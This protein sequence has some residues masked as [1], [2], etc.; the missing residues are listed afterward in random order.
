MTESAK[1]VQQWLNFTGLQPVSCVWCLW[2]NKGTQTAAWVPTKSVHISVCPFVFSHKEWKFVLWGHQVL[3]VVLGM[4]GQKPMCCLYLLII[5]IKMKYKN[6]LLFFFCIVMML[7]NL[8][9]LLRSYYSRF[10]QNNSDIFKILTSPVAIIRCCPWMVWSAEAAILVK[11]HPMRPHFEEDGGW[12][13][14]FC[15]LEQQLNVNWSCDVVYVTPG[16][17]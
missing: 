14:T 16:D 11:S 6:V 7:R 10:S 3:Y 13:K 12:Y 5:W 8:V 1:V 17:G 4:T 15:V 2:G 9:P